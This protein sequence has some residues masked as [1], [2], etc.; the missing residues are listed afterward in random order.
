MGT[1]FS[2]ASAR[3]HSVAET[4]RWTST[5]SVDAAK[6]RGSS[7]PSR[8]S[9]MRIVWWVARPRRAATAWNCTLVDV[10]VDGKA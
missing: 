8:I 10:S 6:M 7:V 5:D 1:L 3:L 2:S 4:S 9:C